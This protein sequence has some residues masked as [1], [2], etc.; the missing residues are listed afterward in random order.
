LKYATGIRI[1]HV[2]CLYWTTKNGSTFLLHRLSLPSIISM[3]D[4]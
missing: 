3:A 1:I 4:G 2:F